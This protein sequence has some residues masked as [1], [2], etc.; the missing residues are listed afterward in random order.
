[1][2]RIKEWKHATARE[3]ARRLREDEAY[4]GDLQIDYISG[5]GPFDY[6][7]LMRLLGEHGSNVTGLEFV[8]FVEEYRGLINVLERFIENGWFNLDDLRIPKFSGTEAEFKQ[9]MTLIPR[10]P[11]Q[12]LHIPIGYNSFEST[13]E[14]AITIPNLSMLEFLL[15]TTYQMNTDLRIVLASISE[16]SSNLIARHIGSVIGLEAFRILEHFMNG[17]PRLRV[18]EIRGS[19]LSQSTQSDI[20][21]ILELYNHR[22]VVRGSAIDDARYMKHSAVAAKIKLIATERAALLDMR[23]Y[24]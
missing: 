7:E 18:F 14:F 2:P 11:I 21:K 24:V 3:H 23:E 22:L 16:Y 20:L 6:N 19:V 10:F 1:M 4:G 15:I 13:K 12:V 8:F 5:S 17:P 9:I